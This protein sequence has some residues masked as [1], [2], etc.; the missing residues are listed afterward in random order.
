MKQRLHSK[1]MAGPGKEFDILHVLQ[2]EEDVFRMPR[3]RHIRRHSVVAYGTGEKPP[4][5]GVGRDGRP[6]ITSSPSHPARPCGLSAMKMPLCVVGVVPARVLGVSPR[7]RAVRVAYARSRENISEQ[8]RKYHFSIY[9]LWNF[10][11]NFLILSKTLFL[12]SHL[13]IICYLC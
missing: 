11:A 2:D 6:D 12:P 3:Q 10:P 4:K 9:C 7:K 8:C 13:Q 1:N 5:P